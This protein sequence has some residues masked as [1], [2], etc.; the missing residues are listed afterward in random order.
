VNKSVKVLAIL[1]TAMMATAVVVQAEGEKQAGDQ[2][3][4]QTEVKKQ[5]I[6]PVMGNEVNTNLFVDHQ[7]KR[8]YVCCKACLKKVTATPEKYIKQLEAE[9]ITLDKTPQAAMTNTPAAT[10]PQLQEEQKEDEHSA[11]QH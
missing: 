9:G 1:V 7:G 11:H 2:A 6:C 3:A 5:T 8:V 4:R 10:A